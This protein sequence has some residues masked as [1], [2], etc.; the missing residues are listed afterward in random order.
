M[1]HRED[2]QHRGL[3]PTNIFVDVDDQGAHSVKVGDFGLGNLISRE[4]V[5]FYRRLDTDIRHQRSAAT[6]QIYS[7]SQTAQLFPNSSNSRSFNIPPI[8]KLQDPISPNI[9]QSRN[10][11]EDLKK[12]LM[13]ESENYLPEEF[14]QQS[15]LDRVCD[16]TEMKSLEI[17]GNVKLKDLENTAV[18]TPELMDEKSDMFSLGWVFRFTM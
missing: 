9:I 2:V 5:A 7:S 14:F 3:R 15:L 12:E 4:T 10:A 18:S 1:M 13:K 11:L 17:V 8:P 6:N 16:L